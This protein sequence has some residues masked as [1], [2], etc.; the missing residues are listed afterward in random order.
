MKPFI[1]VIL[2]L[3]YLCSLCASSHAQTLTPLIK[4][5]K[6]SFSRVSGNVQKAAEAMPE[7]NYSYKPTPDMRSFGQLMG[8][9]ADVES[10]ICAAVSGQ[11]KPAS[12]ADKTAKADLVAALKQSADLCNSAW[13]S[14]TDA[15][16][17]Q[18][19]STGPRQ[20]T[21]LGLMLANTSHSSEEYGYLAVYLRLKGVVPPSTA[22]RG[23]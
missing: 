20:T 11:T 12:V 7:E 10:R 9:I 16:A 17:M 18:A 1:P 15:T 19:I 4:E 13:D 5:S 2:V 3:T 23:K 8:H 21:K 22:E 6:E 14:L